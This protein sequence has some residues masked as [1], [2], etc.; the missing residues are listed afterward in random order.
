MCETVSRKKY[1]VFVI[2]TC[3]ILSAG[4]PNYYNE[5]HTQQYKKLITSELAK[6]PKIKI[7]NSNYVLSKAMIQM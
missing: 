5:R 1:W 6:W 3:L 4:L 7:G 2:V